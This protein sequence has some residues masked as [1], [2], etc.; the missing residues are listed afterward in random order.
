MS[1][2]MKSLSEGEDH[3]KTK[4]KKTQK[5]PKLKKIPIKLKSK[6]WKIK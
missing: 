4:K 5:K 1:Q 3:P 6:N 2:M